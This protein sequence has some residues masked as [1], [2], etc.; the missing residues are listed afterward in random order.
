MSI[1]APGEL[2]ISGEPRP[3]VAKHGGHSKWLGLLLC[4]LAGLLAFRIIALTFNA[5]D[6]FFDEAQYWA[7]SEELAAG[8]FSKPPALA[9][10]IR[11][12]TEILGDAPWAI[13]LASP[14][15]HTVTALVTY[16]IAARLYGPQVGFWSGLAFA[17]LPG[18][19]LSSGI[20]STDVPLLMFWSVALYALIRLLEITSPEA[21]ERVASQRSSTVG[22]GLVFGVAL[23]LGL[24]SK[25]AAFYLLIC[26]AVYLI[27]TPAARSILKARGFWLALLVAAFILA[28]NIWW[29]VDNGG[30]TVA[31]TADNAKWGG[32]MFQPLKALEFFG[33]QFGVF[34]P[35]LFGA[36]LVIIF[37]AWR[38]GL[39]SADRL[40]L[41]FCLPIILIITVQAFLS[42]A[43]ANWAATAYVAATPL[44]IATM[45]RDADWGWL[46]AS[47]ALRLTLV[48]GLA[49]ATAFAPHLKVPGLPNPFAR[50]LGWSEITKAISADLDTKAYGPFNAIVTTDRETS[51]IMVYYLRE[52][53]QKANAKLN[54]WLPPTQTGLAR[55]HYQLT[56]PLR[57]AAGDGPFLVI[58]KPKYAKALAR[59]FAETK[60]LNTIETQL[61]GKKRKVLV[62]RVNGYE[63][64]Q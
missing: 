55:D 44:V 31:H 13:R 58:T 11:A 64:R 14:V 16:A 37:R 25:Y 33:A 6:L 29:N 42:R 32:K 60:T 59:H 48:A 9:F 49:V 19:T 34:G 39:P 3:A 46:K 47:T 51:A 4:I 61:G 52:S 7:W 30:V 8:Y 1:S 2:G 24:M 54:A 43:H 35:I 27:A 20:I 10:I 53:L 50:N 41:C 23:G 12:F 26:L 17:T 62:M 40:L 56:R 63:A 21:L 38:E 45:I 15:M 18:V 28:P 5:T 22:W 57:P 36:L